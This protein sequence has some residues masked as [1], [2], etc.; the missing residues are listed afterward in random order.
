MKPHRTIRLDALEE[1]V[2]DH[3]LRPA[4]RLIR[5]VEDERHPPGDASTMT[6]QKLGHPGD[7]GRVSIMATTVMTIYQLRGVLTAR[8]IGH[9]KRVHVSANQKGGT[10]LSTLEHGHDPGPTH[11]LVDDESEAAHTCRERRRG[12]RFLE[13]QLWMLMELPSK[14]DHRRRQAVDLMTEIG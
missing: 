10:C 6:R 12:A 3:S 2:V 8:R 14:R 4:H 9:R 5:G 7:D 1:A 13:G 11:T